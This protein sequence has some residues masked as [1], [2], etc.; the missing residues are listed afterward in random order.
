VQAEDGR[1]GEAVNAAAAAI[2]YTADP[3]LAF[4]PTLAQLGNAVTPTGGPVARASAGRNVGG[5]LMCGDRT[6]G[7]RIAAA[8]VDAERQIQRARAEMDDVYLELLRRG[9]AVDLVP[10][11]RRDLVDDAAQRTLWSEQTAQQAR[12]AELQERLRLAGL[13]EDDAH[14]R[15]V[16]AEQSR[17]QWAA[18]ARG[19]GVTSGDAYRLADP[20]VRDEVRRDEV[21]RWR[22]QADRWQTAAGRWRDL[23]EGLARVVRLMSRLPVRPAHL[24]P[25]AVHSLAWALDPRGTQ[26]APVLPVE[27]VADIRRRAVDTVADTLRL[28]GV[29]VTDAG[30]AA[31]EQQLFTLDVEEAS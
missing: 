16:A 2:A 15:R 18:I 5:R 11:H 27:V 9:V 19:A 1:A 4:W 12:I 26:P 13:R 29:T 14:S 30:R 24:H 10:E 31:I 17:D 7:E 25:D 20:A 3:A 22:A 6:A 28:T 21:R 8:Q 23:A